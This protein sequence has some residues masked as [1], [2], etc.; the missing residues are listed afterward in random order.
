MVNRARLQAIRASLD[1]IETL[2]FAEI[3]LDEHQQRQ[4]LLEIAG[5]QHSVDTL[6][7]DEHMYVVSR[8][9]A[10]LYLILM[11]ELS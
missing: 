11:G 9:Q 4:C 2:L 10:L 3:V 8:C 7:D 6:S 1:K 5:I